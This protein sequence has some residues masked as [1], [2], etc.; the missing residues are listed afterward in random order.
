M[1]SYT[2]S[3]FG[4]GVGT[5]TLSCRFENGQYYPDLDPT[6]DNPIRRNILIDKENCVVNIVD[7]SSSEDLQDNPEAIVFVNDAFIIF[8]AIDDRAS[9]ERAEK[10]YNFI[11][12]VKK[13][14]GIPH[15]ICATKCDLEDK[16]AVSKEEGEALAARTGGSF[17]ETSALNNVNVEAPIIELVRKI[18]QLQ[19]HKKQKTEKTNGNQK[20]EACEIY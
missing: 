15:V 10:L 5:S 9:F 3:A 1:T 20:K 7:Y 8:Y 4:N 18:R 6:V 12:E 11:T 14:T 2:I 13:F 19:N 17:Y 16:R